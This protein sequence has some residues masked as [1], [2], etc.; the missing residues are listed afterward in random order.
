M[1]ADLPPWSTAYL[2]VLGLSFY[3]FTLAGARTFEVNPGDETPSGIAQFSFLVTGTI[4]TLFLNVGKPLPLSNALV[5]ATL[6]LAALALYEWARDVIR[7]RGFHLAWTGDVPDALCDEGPYRLVRHPLYSSYIL[8]FLAVAVAYPGPISLTI[9]VCNLGL[10]VQAAITD[11][12]S[13]ARS[14]LASEYAAY[15]ARTGMFLPRLNA[16]K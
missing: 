2:F 11:E 1:L 16:S 13:L 14:D 4:G 5:S 6:L 7:G 15:K 9:L 3:Y 10:F 8:T 12:R